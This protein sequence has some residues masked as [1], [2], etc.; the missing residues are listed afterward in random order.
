MFPEELSARLLK[1][2]TMIDSNAK[3]QE[4]PKGDDLQKT[5]KLSDQALAVA[6]SLRTSTISASVL[7]GVVRAVDAVTVASLGAL[8]LVSAAGPVAVHPLAVLG[9]LIGVVLVT[10]VF[11]AADCYQVSVMRTL[12]PQL[13]RIMIG[14]SLIFGAFFTIP[15]LIDYDLSLPPTWLGL[16][17]G[18]TLLTLLAMRL[19]LAV[20][21]RRWTKAGRLEHRAVIVGGGEAAAELIRD[22]E[23]QPSHA[24]RICGIFDD[25]KNDRSPAVVAGYPKLGSVAD[26]VEFARIAR[27][28]MLIVTIPINAERRLLEFLKQLWVLP[29]DIRLSA[30]TASLDFRDR[31][32]SFIGGVP[33]VDVVDKPVA[34]WDAIVKRALDLLVATLALILLSPIMLATALAIRLDSPGPVLF[35]Q[36]RYGFNN[37]VIDVFKFRSMY[38]HLS[39]PLAKRVVTKGDSRITRVGRFIRKTSIDELPQ[40]FNVLS[41]E[42]SLVGPRPHAVNAHTDERLWEQVVDGYFARHKVK[43]GITGWAQVNGW[44]GEVDTP[45][46]I[47]KRVE[48]DIYYI[49]NWS[50]LFD[51]YIMIRTPFAL[52]NTENAY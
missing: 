29:V 41:G 20:L 9:I 25:R 21:L 16:W 43:P 52:F 32:S 40:L 35:R 10:L 5:R 37:E 46:K 4:I 50:I 26:L 36:K 38:H 28:D 3:E 22:I 44:R 30:H 12:L 33:F 23:K 19:W 18:L 39:D 6:E 1:S 42:L 14:L 8:T 7:T 2:V 17:F 24:I 11:Q 45:E 13:T 34:D 31:A 47:H 27:V 49:E 15:V 48:Y 51:I